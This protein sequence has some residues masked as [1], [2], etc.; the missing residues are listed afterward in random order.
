MLIIY[1]QAQR[2]LHNIC[3]P[4]SSSNNSSSVPPVDQRTA[5][6]NILKDLDEWRLR[7]SWLDLHLMYEQLRSSPSDLSQWLDNVAQSAIQVFCQ[8]EAPSNNKSEKT[9][10]R[11]LHSMNLIAPL[12]SKL[13]RQVQGRVLKVSN[14]V[15][16]AVNFG[17]YSS[18]KAPV[19]PQPG[20]LPGSG[21]SL[22]AGGLGSSGSVGLGTQAGTPSLVIIIYRQCG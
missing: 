11:K 9:R 7:I 3:H 6:T 5:I 21:G 22:N 20:A 15:L 1:T 2:V 14:Q 8:A 4:E 16:N 13:P 17:A 18:H 12:I 10:R 19:V